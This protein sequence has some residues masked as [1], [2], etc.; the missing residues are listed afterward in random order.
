[1]TG[2]LDETENAVV[3]IRCCHTFRVLK[4][5]NLMRAF[6]ISYIKFLIAP[7][8]SALFSKWGMHPSMKLIT[9]CVLAN[10]T[11]V[12][13]RN[14]EFAFKTQGKELLTTMHLRRKAHNCSAETDQL[15]NGVFMRLISIC[16][17]FFF[18]DIIRYHLSFELSRNFF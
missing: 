6:L 5:Y 10:V 8:L 15:I 16:G 18:Q 7:P 1:M 17:T 9:V 11:S 14:N 4:S 2:G 13:Y 3:Q 12:T